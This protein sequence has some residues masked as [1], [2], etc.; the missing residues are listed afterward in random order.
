MNLHVIRR[1]GA[2]TGL[3]QSQPPVNWPPDV[4]EEMPDRVHLIRSYV[5][6]ED[7]GRLGSFSIYEAR[8]AEAIIE[9]ADRV[10]TPGDETFPV[11]DTV[12][13]RGDPDQSR[14]SA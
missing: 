9:H 4:N 5:V 13:V 12:I 7:D 14:T 6:R 2:W 8:N 10:G 3:A 1:P 11:I